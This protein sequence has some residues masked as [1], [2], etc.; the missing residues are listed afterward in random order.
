MLIRA[1][2]GQRVV[3][4]KTCAKKAAG[5]ALSHDIDGNVKREKLLLLLMN[6]I[7]A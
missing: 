6:E 2:N 7:N 3:Y 1:Q 5:F 4:L